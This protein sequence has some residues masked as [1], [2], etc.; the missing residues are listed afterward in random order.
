VPDA[1]CGKAKRTRALVAGIGAL[2]LLAGVLLVSRA[3]RPAAPSI[4]AGSTS[5]WFAAADVAAFTGE[6]EN[7]TLAEL[8]LPGYTTRSMLPAGA[9]GSVVAMLEQPGPG[10][11]RVLCSISPA[12]KKAQVLFVTPAS[13]RF[14][15][16]ASAGGA[17]GSLFENYGL[18]RAA[19][20][21]ALVSMRDLPSPVS[22]PNA[23]AAAA[24]V[25]MHPS[26]TQWAASVVGAD[27]KIAINAYTFTNGQVESRSVV[28]GGAQ[29]KGI[30][31]SRDGQHIAY[32]RETAAGAVALR[33]VPASGS[34]VEPVTLREG[35]FTFAHGAFNADT[36]AIA[37][38]VTRDGELPSIEIVST[39]DGHVL[40]RL[41]DALSAGWEIGSGGL[42]ISAPDQKGAAQLW[43]VTSTAPV[44]RKQLTY[45]D[46]GIDPEVLV[47]PDGTWASAST[48]NTTKPG[49]AFV[50]LRP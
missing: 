43:R 35:I 5:A 34:E 3:L 47:S 19:D 16:L 46:G 13:A 24:R 42:V 22:V 12:A 23:I 20:N 33:V 41:D 26:G 30:A 45:L 25:A 31:Y 27:G 32:L 40:V 28:P 2:V 9:D 17:G 39:Q 6:G 4:A 8:Q 29:I 14:E 50:A 49:I 15:L 21:L 1:A 37:L 18:V 7:V 44:Q 11:K 48:A 36:S 38:S 10:G